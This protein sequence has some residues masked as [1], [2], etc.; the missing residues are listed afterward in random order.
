MIAT[1]VKMGL[2]EEG[3]G[4]ED[5]LFVEGERGDGDDVVVVADGAAAADDGDDSCDAFAASSQAAAL[6]SFD[7]ALPI[8]REL[9]VGL[10]GRPHAE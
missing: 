6:A 9:N 10:G 2:A 4:F 1:K 3:A 5:G 8:A 7:A